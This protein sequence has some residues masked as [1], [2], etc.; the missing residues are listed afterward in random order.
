MNNQNNI[1][2]RTRVPSLERQSVF[3]SKISFG[4]KKI[5]Q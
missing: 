2:T 3:E 1:F 5:I 4:E